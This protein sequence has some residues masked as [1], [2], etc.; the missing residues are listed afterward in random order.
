MRFQLMAGVLWSTLAFAVPVQANIVGHF[1]SVS[2]GYTQDQIVGWICDNTSTTETPNEVALVLLLD[3]QV[4]DSTYLT[5]GGN[6]GIRRNE[7]AWNCENDPF[8]GFV[9]NH[10][11]LPISFTSTKV[12][13]C[14]YALPS[15]PCWEMSG[16]PKQCSSATVPST[17]N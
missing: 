2:L 5:Q 14:Y 16:S 11:V 4:Y 13:L 12:T 10:E 15:G 8:V 17:C 6:W 1:D 9:W 7:V 3:D